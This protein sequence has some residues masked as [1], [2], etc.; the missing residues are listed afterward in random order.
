MEELIEKIIKI[1]EEK[2][3][4]KLVGDQKLKTKA[5]LIFMIF[6]G[7]VK[8]RLQSII[9][10]SIYQLKPTKEERQE[11]RDIADWLTKHKGDAERFIDFQSKLPIIFV[12]STP[13]ID[14]EKAKINRFIDSALNKYLNEQH[15]KKSN[16]VSPNNQG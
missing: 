15:T 2:S 14:T 13:I 6:L 11:M 3:E 7:L 5:D 9:E 12:V 4:Y 10:S 8:Y 16:E 1:Q